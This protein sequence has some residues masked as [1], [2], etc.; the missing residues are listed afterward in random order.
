M[1]NNLVAELHAADA[2]I[3]ACLALDPP[4]NPQL[5]SMSAPAVL[6]PDRQPSFERRH[7]HTVNESAPSRQSTHIP[8]DHGEGVAISVISA[9]QRETGGLIG[10]KRFIVY[11]L[12]ATRFADGAEVTVFRRFREIRSLYYQVRRLRSCK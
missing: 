1:E 4:L 8:E 12:R 10:K 2:K 7:S 3:K 6:N 5:V 9:V 11:G